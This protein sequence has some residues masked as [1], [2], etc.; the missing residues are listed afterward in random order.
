M[1]AARV[2]PGFVEAPCAPPECPQDLLRPHARL[3]SAPR[4]RWGLKLKE[5][6]WRWGGEGC[7]A[8][9][10]L[11]A[12]IA[13]PGKHARVLLTMVGEEEDVGGALTPWES[14]MLLKSTCS[15]ARQLLLGPSSSSHFAHSRRSSETQ[16]FRFDRTPELWRYEWNGFR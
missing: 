16:H 5:H 2:P 12:S 7:A 15:A 4:I 6:L 11:S 14:L 3:L 13:G 1:R 9:G 8:L 10:D